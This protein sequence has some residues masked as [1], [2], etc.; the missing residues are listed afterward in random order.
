[1]GKRIAL[2]VATLLILLFGSPPGLLSQTQQQ[3]PT[4][5]PTPGK[6]KPVR[7]TSHVVLISISGLRAD[8]ANNPESYG[9]KIPGLQL[10]KSKGSSAVGIESVYPSQTVPAH[11]SMLTGVLPADHGI[12]SDYPFDEQSATQSASTFQSAK[13]IKADTIWE[14]AKRENLVTAAIGFPMTADANININLPEAVNFSD[15]SKALSA[16]ATIEKSFPNLLA[17]NF[18][19]LDL[20]QRRFGVLSAEAKLAIGL[21]DALVSKIVTATERAGIGDK[22]AFLIVSDHGVSKVEHEFRPNV[23]L[24]K[25]GFLTLGGQGNINSWRAVAVSFGG[26]AA[27]FLKNPQDETTAKAVEELFREVEKDNSDHPLWRITVRREAARLGADSRATLYLDA[28]PPFQISARATGSTISKTP[29][30]AA[31]GYL[32]S[33]AEMR[34]AMFISGKA[35]KSNQRIE[36]V[37]LIDVAP[38]IAKLLGLEMK[39]A[40]GRVLSEVITQ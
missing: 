17:I 32:P 9:L 16:V 40:R 37:R 33:R 35:I 13:T 28:A 31:H 6:P 7:L 29:D 36:Y 38:T 34:G 5:S 15:E 25:K 10:L 11:V 8:H 26:S 18:T 19:S 20:A 14:A 27:V 1:M 30:R 22:T 12:T 2:T 23:L 3:K 24:A 21:I 4:P 39:S